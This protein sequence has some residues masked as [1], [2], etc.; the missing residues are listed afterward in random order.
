MS[1]QWRSTPRPQNAR[2]PRTPSRARRLYLLINTLHPAEIAALLR[3][4]APHDRRW[5]RERIRR[6]NRADVLAKLGP[7]MRRELLSAGAPPV[8]V[9]PLHALQRA[10]ENGDAADFAAE[11]PEVVVRHVLDSLER[12]DRGRASAARHYPPHTA[13]QLMD[14]EVLCVRPNVSVEVVLRYLRARAP[15]PRELDAVFVVDRQDRFLGA[16]PLERL[17][18]ARRET[19]AKELIS[20]RTPAIVPRMSAWDVAKLFADLNL[21]SL[22]V[23]GRRGKL[24]GRITSDDV[25]DVMREET[26]TALRRMGHLPARDDFLSGVLRTVMHRSAWLAFGLIG[27][28]VTSLMI[29]Q[30]QETIHRAVEVAALMPVVASLGGVF[31]V[32]TATLTVRGLALGQIGPHNYVRLLSREVLI[33]LA[34]SVLLG[35]AVWIATVHLFGNARMSAASVAGLGVTFVVSGTLGVLIPLAVQRVGFDPVFTASGITVATDALAYVSVVGL[36]TWLLT[37]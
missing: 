35:M 1:A 8:A 33:A 19:L 15:L 31:A 37:L 36:A 10:G 13:G 4:L 12:S 18:S 27:A 16:I 30:F 5:A 32:Q 24:L 25:V 26:E 20:A 22:A 3:V 9:E 11:L 14:T 29:M 21:T 6:S 28:C 34:L 2:H 17:V 23:V 7:E